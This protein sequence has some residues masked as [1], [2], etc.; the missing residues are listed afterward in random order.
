MKFKRRGTELVPPYVPMADIVFNLVLF[1]LI[2]A[3]TKDDRHINWTPASAPTTTTVTSARA[4]VAVDQNGK[5]YLNTKEIGL[6]EL[7]DAI[8][9]ELGNA[10]PDKRKVLLKIH[11]STQAA[12]FAPILEAVGQAGGEAVH[13]LKDER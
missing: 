9:G 2:M 12:T 4:T 11:E 7:A 3:K 8:A 1:F 10:A 6:R 13:V 5:V